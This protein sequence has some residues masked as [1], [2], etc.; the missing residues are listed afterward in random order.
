MSSLG[1]LDDDAVVACVVKAA[2][3]SGAAAR[4]QA[5]SGRLDFRLVIFLVTWQD[6]HTTPIFPVRRRVPR[7]AARHGQHRKRE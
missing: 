7:L 6:C 4:R 3:A 5:A 1:S 2:A